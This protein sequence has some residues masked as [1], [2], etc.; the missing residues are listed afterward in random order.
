MDQLE[1]H[2]YL[3]QFFTEND[4]T[5]IDE[6]K[7]H[8][9]IQ[10]SIDMD[11]ALMNRPFYWHYTEKIG[12]VPNPMKLT[13]IT[14]SN[15]APTDLKGELIHFGSPRLHQIFQT[16]QDRGSHAVLYESIDTNGTSTPLKPWL[17]INGSVS[18]RCDHK[19]DQFFSIGL[20]LITGEM[21]HDIHAK[22]EQKQFQDQI[23]NYCFTMTPII[24]PKS[25][26]ER[27][28]NY[29]LEVEEAKEHGWASEALKRLKE[30]EQLLEGFYIDDEREE[31]YH[32]EKSAIKAQYEPSIHI[33]VINGGLFYFSNHPLT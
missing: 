17:I 13:L 27:I 11:K 24:K 4:S 32:Q 5:I 15:E 30:D 28:K 9:H 20:S 22:I 6:S 1:I 26:V 21:I 19:M 14:N 16:A 23:P 2:N 18:Y 29:I 25:G 33:S 8:L 12:G 3:K 10:L 31:T 7:G